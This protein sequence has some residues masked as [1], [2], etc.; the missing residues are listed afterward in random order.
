MQPTS[1]QILRE[2]AQDGNPAATAT[3]LN[4]VLQ[5][6]QI[7]VKTSIHQ[8]ELKIVLLSESVTDKSVVLFLLRQ[9]LNQFVGK[10]ITKVKIHCHKK[11]SYFIK[12]RYKEVINY[13]IWVHEEKFTTS[14][15]TKLI[16]PKNSY[17][18]F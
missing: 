10:S 17:D 6:H 9:E 13:N 2:L 8:G 1:N 15:K 4:Q 11:L 7:S 3:L 16:A 18:L 14:E 12:N 5:S